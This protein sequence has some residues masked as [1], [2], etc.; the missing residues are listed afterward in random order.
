MEQHNRRNFL[1]AGTLTGAAM[2]ASSAF[3]MFSA[4]ESNIAID[5]TTE[6]KKR[7]RRI[8]GSGKHSIEVNFG[9]GLGCMGMS[10]HRSFIPDKKQW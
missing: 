3:G 4:G 6:L 8:L 2:W 7:K 10:W 1:K 9:M 5:K